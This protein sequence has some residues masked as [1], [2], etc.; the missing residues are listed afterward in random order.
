MTHSAL[1]S[2]LQE[3]EARYVAANP[4]SQAHYQKAKAYLPDGSQ[5]N[6]HFSR[7]SGHRQRSFSGI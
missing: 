6:G 2:A 3:A 7:T 1:K 5:L 4:N